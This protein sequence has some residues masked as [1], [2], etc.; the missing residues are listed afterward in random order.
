M[1]PRVEWISHRD[2]ARCFVRHVHVMKMAAQSES[3]H[4][5]SAS[6]RRGSGAK[7]HSPADLSLRCLTDL[8]LFGLHAR[9]S[10][11]AV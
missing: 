9:I 10:C 1:Y 11:A 6:C 3:D 5:S 8:F 7:K 4:E 2:L